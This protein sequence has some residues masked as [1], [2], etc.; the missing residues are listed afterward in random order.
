[1]CCTTFDMLLPSHA[2][3]SS[4]AWQH[5]HESMC[6]VHSACRSPESVPSISCFSSSVWGH[7]VAMGFILNLL[8]PPHR[9]DFVLEA[10][11]HSALGDV[12]RSGRHANLF[13]HFG[14]RHVVD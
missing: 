5:W 7:P 3:S 4:R 1:M 9:L 8:L 2:I 10:C 6:W 11:E 13:G 12:N 14:D